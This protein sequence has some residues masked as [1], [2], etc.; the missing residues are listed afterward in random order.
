MRS[1]GTQLYTSPCFCVNLCIVFPLHP[2]GLGLPLLG[3]SLPECPSPF[4]PCH[5]LTRSL[6]LPTSPSWSRLCGPRRNGTDY[7]DKGVL[8]LPFFCQEKT[9][10]TNPK[11]P[12]GASESLPV[13]F[14]RLCCSVA[15]SWPTLCDPK[16]CS[17]PGFPVL[18]YLPELAQTCVHQVS[19]A[20][21]PAHPLSSPSL[22]A[23]NLSQHQG[24]FQ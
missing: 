22:P 17:A 23:F 16:D 15:Q 7:D 6:E 20:I 13:Q 12:D 8:C 1:R 2:S 10:I 18:P 21:Q 5:V 4:L 19:D 24:L 9:F 14:P 11:Q 3:F